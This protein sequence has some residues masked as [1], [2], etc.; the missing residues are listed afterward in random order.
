MLC[1]SL[2]AAAD[3]IASREKG[4]IENLI[5]HIKE[6]SAEV[7][8]RNGREY[9]AGTAAR[10]LRRKWQVNTEKVRTAEDFVE[11]IASR[12]STTGAPYRIRM[13]DG[14]ETECGEYLSKLLVSQESGPPLRN[15]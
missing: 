11:K 14:T 6:M 2:A 13:K 3:E 1:L 4:R 8:I 15:R 5:G 7:F 10:F 12:S 9:D